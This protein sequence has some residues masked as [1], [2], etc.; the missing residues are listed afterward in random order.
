V[1]KTALLRHFAASRPHVHFQATDAS[2]RDNLDALMERAAASLGRPALAAARPLDIEKALHLIVDAW[3]ASVGAGEDRRLA[4]VLDEVPNLFTASPASASLLQRFI[5]ELSAT[6]TV[7]LFLCGSAVRVMEAEVLGQRS[8]LYGRRTAQLRLGPLPFE[9]WRPFCP[10]LS[11]RDRL[12]LHAATGG[13]PAYLVPIEG[14]STA[15][16]AL[17]T[18]FFRR[19]SLLL[20]EADFLLRAELSVLHSYASILRAVAAGAT[21]LQEI[22]ERVGSD[23]RAVS[24]YVATLSELGYVVRETSLDE[25]APEKSRKGRYRVVDGL[26]RFHFRFVQ[27]HRDVIERGDGADLFEQ[28]VLPALPAFAGPVY[29]DVTRERLAREARVRFGA[30]ALRVG[31][32]YGAWGEIDLALELLD[33]TWV[34]GECKA[35]TAPMRADVLEAL[36]AKTA[37]V[38]ELAGKTVRLV[39][40]SL[41]GFTEGCATRAAGYGIDLLS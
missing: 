6:S 31:R 24:R 23:G 19:T 4:L 1:G 22:A 40:A 39:A 14:A 9:A 3:E 28:R 29:E 20:P 36:R 25:P 33:G 13:V 35:T 2:A 5:D 8:P 15:A 18:L 17:Q 37:S 11:P 34:V 32:L 10:D 27:P 30:P 16:E 26:L 41:A 21:R 7:R 12:W 38:P